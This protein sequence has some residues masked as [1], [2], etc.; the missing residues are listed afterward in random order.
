MVSTA[1][2]PMPRWRILSS[3]TAEE[4][5]VKPPVLVSYHYDLLNILHEDS[6]QQADDHGALKRA[7]DM[8]ALLQYHGVTAP[9]AQ[10]GFHHFHQAGVHAGKDGATPVRRL[11]RATAAARRASPSFSVTARCEPEYPA[12][13]WSWLLMDK[14]WLKAAKTKARKNSP[15]DD[16][17]VGAN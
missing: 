1:F 7:D 14:L 4:A 2:S 6:H 10:G 13:M 12:I 15:G 16:R 3:S 8:P 9:D 11:S 5:W 17:H